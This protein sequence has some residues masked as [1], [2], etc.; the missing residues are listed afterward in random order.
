MMRGL[1]VQVATAYPTAI[2]IR[3]KALVVHLESVRMIVCK[4]Q[5]LIISVPGPET[6][7]Q[8]AFPAPDSPFIQDLVGRINQRIASP[9]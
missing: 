6:P 5:I 7:P 8:S 1:G 9:G 2:L 4:D 3:E